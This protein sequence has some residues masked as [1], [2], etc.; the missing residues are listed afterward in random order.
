MRVG[1]FGRPTLNPWMKQ[2]S[3]IRFILTDLMCLFLFLLLFL[4][5]R[6]LI[7]DKK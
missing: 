5:I 2:R 3:R 4:I 6:A 7:Q 1:A